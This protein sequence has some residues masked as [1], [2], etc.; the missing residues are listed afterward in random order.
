[1]FNSNLIVLL[2]FAFTAHPLIAEPSVVVTLGSIGDRIRAQN[3]DLAAARMRIQEALGR[4]NQAGRHANPE[5][6]TS[7]EHDPS[8]REGKFEVGFSQRFPITDRL[9][10]EKDVS[11]TELKS[12]EAEVREVERQLISKAREAMVKILANRQRRELLQQ[13]SAIS[14]EFAGFLAEI[15]QKGEGSP[16]DAGQAKLESA[17]LAMEMRLLGAG[18]TSL[19]GELR[20]LLGMRPG[21]ALSVGGILPEASLP[22]SAADPSNRP[23][24]QVAKLDAQAAAQGVALE[25]ARRY[26]D[27]EGGLFAAAERTEDAPEGYENEAIIGLRFKVALPFWNKN[28][29]AIQEAEAKRNR[30]ELEAVALSRNICLEAEAARAEMAEWANVIAEINDTLLPLAEEQSTLAE[31]TYRNGQGEIQSVL[32]SREKRLQLAAARLD[33]LREFHLARV[34]HE[35]ALAKP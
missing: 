33:A 32:R 8:F 29:G 19:I 10:L 7:I 17:S 20:P 21:E 23:D 14:K 15:A 3:P 26:D 27:V 34:R 22:E 1:M 5:F 28:E 18:E 2:A 12:S 31:T 24:F 25:Q 9:R 13:Q 30:K 35:T 6:E 4:I 11:L 16:L